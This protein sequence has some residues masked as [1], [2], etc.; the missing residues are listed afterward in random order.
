MPNSA[1]KLISTQIQTLS[2]PA[3][4]NEPARV[5]KS[6]LNLSAT[7]RSVVIF[8]IS[9]SAGC[10][11]R[12][13]THT[14]TFLASGEPSTPMEILISRNII[15][16]I[17][18]LL[19]LF[20]TFFLAFGCTATN[21]PMQE[22]TTYGQTQAECSAL[23]KSCPA[24]MFYSDSRGCV[25]HQTFLN[26]ASCLASGGKWT[27]GG[28]AAG[29]GPEVDLY[30]CICNASSH[31]GCPTGYS[32][33]T[34]DVYDVCEKT[35]SNEQKL[36]SDAS[37]LNS[38]IASCLASGSYRGAS[39]YCLDSRVNPALKSSA[40]SNYQICKYIENIT[41]SCYLFVSQN[42]SSDPQTVCADAHTMGKSD[43]CYY[44]F[45]LGRKQKTYCEKIAAQDASDDCYSSFVQYHIFECD[46]IV[47]AS[48]KN[49][50]FDSLAQYSNDTSTCENIQLG[51][52]R[53]SCYYT[54]A[55]EN[56][57]A[58]IC[59]KMADPT[60]SDRC[61]DQNIFYTVMKK[62][63]SS[64]SAT[65]TCHSTNGS[66]AVSSGQCY[67]SE[68]KSKKDPALCNRIWFDWQKDECYLKMA[69]LLKDTSLCEM[70][71]NYSGE[72]T[73]DGCYL[74][75]SATTGNGSIA[76]DGFC[77]NYGWSE[78][79]VGDEV[80]IGNW[81]VRLADVT[82]TGISCIDRTNAYPLPSAVFDVM[83]ENNSVV[84]RLS[85]CPA[86]VTDYQNTGTGVS[87]RVYVRWSARGMSSGSSSAI[88]WG[89]AITCSD[90]SS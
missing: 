39:G 75:L 6:L 27:Y 41:D 55:N 45:A 54:M 72:Y 58:T 34:S 16:S 14:G 59:L 42:P 40:L 10:V 31:T 4:R 13:Q 12:H 69:Q 30:S 73:R 48:K 63:P 7:S 5:R 60:R 52:D 64:E 21:A 67:I 66:E 17:S 1:L 28:S 2:R 76:S 9:P 83:G 87:L 33:N 22:K 82:G 46:K 85:A 88:V 68:A 44:G 74:I 38:A 65:D 47:D 18:V 43:V 19:V 23:S 62:Y 57:N 24:D 15:L 11:R 25:C 32:C 84:D 89:R 56:K 90:Q 77:P 79:H 81:I 53:D 61:Y 78:M 37:E 29:R 50:C 71:H 20:A 35:E 51:S 80:K 3:G 36:K 70:V 49:R 8:G 26:S 86:Q